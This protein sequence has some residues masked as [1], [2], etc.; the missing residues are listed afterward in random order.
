MLKHLSL[1]PVPY[2]ETLL[3]HQLFQIYESMLLTWRSGSQNLMLTKKL[4]SQALE[5]RYGFPVSF[6]WAFLVA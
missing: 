4:R 1:F 6:Y 3:L 2:F 5:A